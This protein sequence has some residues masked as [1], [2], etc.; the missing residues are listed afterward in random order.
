M[1]PSEHTLSLQEA[2][3]LAIQYHNIGEL[4]QAEAIYRQILEIAPHNGEVLHLL[5]IIAAQLENYETALELIEK[6]IQFDRSNANF[7][8]SLGNLFWYQD[9][10]EDAGRC[11]R[12][13]LTL[14]PEFAQAHNGFGNVLRQLDYLDIAIEHYQ[15]SLALNPDFAEAHNNL[16]NALKDQGQFEQAIQSYQQA[17]NLN[18]DY[19][20][21]HTNLAA[22][23]SEQGQPT[24]I[25]AYQRAIELNPN[26]PQLHHD[27]GNTFSDL[28]Q[29]INAITSYQKA[30]DCFP[31]YAEAYFNLGIV[32]ARLGHVHEAIAQY[33]R[34]LEIKPDF[35]KAHHGLLMALN[36]A[37]GVT[38]AMIYAEQ[39]RFNEQYFKAIVPNTPK[40]VSESDSQRRL[41]IGYVSADFQKHSVAYFMEGI[42]A[43]H[44]HG[45]FE[46]FCYYSHT[47]VDEITQRFTGYA[48]HWINCAQLSDDALAEQIR[49]DQIDILIDLMGHPG[50]NRL[51]VFARKPAPVQMT[52]LGSPTTTAL[53]TMDYRITDR[54]LDPENQQVESA[55]SEIPIRL[56]HNLICYRPEPKSPEVNALP[57]LKNGYITFSSLNAYYKIN[58]ALLSLWA[59]VLNAIPNAKLLLKPSSSILNDP[60]TQ[61]SIKK[62]FEQVGIHPER[63]ILEGL[64]P[65]PA[66][67][68]SYHNVDIALD[69]YPYNGGTTTCE[70][71][72]MGIPV[73]TL[74]GETH[75]SR[76]GLSHLAT[77]GLNELVAY[78]PE[79]YIKI[80]VELANN[81]ERLAQLRAGMRQK[82]Q[83]SALMDYVG[84]TRHLE[85]AYQAHF[86]RPF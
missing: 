24:A 15:R 22:V 56:P 67:L 37:P 76:V 58:S 26:D 68:K 73:V 19:L 47:V 28:G 63:L 59:Q 52:Y 42:L 3:E 20:E 57:A 30:I 48:D 77:L 66:Y 55:R 16:A 74:V 14:N 17:I 27:L 21:A 82:M 34:A 60:V 4:Q 85:D 29:I 49:K 79:D 23:L 71:L 80:C 38:Q 70:A 13:S 35:R 7:Y 62:Q 36:Y 32:L 65:A 31:N 18:A 64:T 51:G 5:G 69:S 61:E 43:H 33:R 54:H 75:V 84:F 78:T 44:D 10:F 11:Y 9:K 40:R 8:N 25:L 12:Y 46:I 1:T 72:W 86:K 6:A 2:F 53:T 81:L 41:K 39:Q 45:H 83:A 50:N